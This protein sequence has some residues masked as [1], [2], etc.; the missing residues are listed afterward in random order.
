MKNVAIILCLFLA[1]AS[2]ALAYRYQT[3]SVKAQNYL[4]E[5]RFSRMTAEESAAQLETRGEALALDLGRAVRRA[6]GFE[7]KVEQ[8]ERVNTDLKAQLSAAGKK[9]QDL[10]KTLEAVNHVVS[11][12]E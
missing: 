12:R 10:E 11:G 2:L 5:E 3:K 6:E 1:M 9:I 7:K 8:V 4:T